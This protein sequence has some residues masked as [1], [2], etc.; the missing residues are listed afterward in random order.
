[1][2]IS[3][4][5]NP[6]KKIEFPILTTV[7]HINNNPDYISPLDPLPF[8]ED[9]G[10]EKREKKKIKDKNKSNQFYFNLNLIFGRILYI[11]VNPTITLTITNTQ[12]KG[13]NWTPFPKNQAWREIK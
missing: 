4:F 10:R 11:T 5:Y 3:L 7:I 13:G 9:K 1:M 8:C 2:K 12:R 6:S